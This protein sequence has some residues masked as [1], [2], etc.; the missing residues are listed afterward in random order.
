MK[1]SHSES[2]NESYYPSDTIAPNKRQKADSVPLNGHLHHSNAY[3]GSNTPS[4]SNPLM[5]LPELAAIASSLEP[6]DL[7]STGTTHRHHSHPHPHI[8]ANEVPKNLEELRQFRDGLRRDVINGK[9]ELDKLSARLTSADKVLG[10]L[11]KVLDLG[12]RPDL[13]QYLA[14]LPTGPAVSLPKRNRNHV[15]SEVPPPAVEMSIADS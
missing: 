7:P 10:I 11:N 2:L 13:E 9:I 4:P 8:H 3:P 12:P 14:S 5:S 15:F 1:R 6:M